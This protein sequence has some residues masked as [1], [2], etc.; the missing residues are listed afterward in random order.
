MRRHDTEESSTAQGLVRMQQ[1]AV[2]VGIY[3]YVVSM[4]LI[5]LAPAVWG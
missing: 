4:Y 3:M 5:L 1:A 2:G